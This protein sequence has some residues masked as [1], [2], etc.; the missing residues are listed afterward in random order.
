ME[1]T[2]EQVLQGIFEEYKESYKA[3]LNLTDYLT[4]TA[5]GMRQNLSMLREE[6]YKLKCKI[7]EKELKKCI[8]R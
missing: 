2:D 1:P 4:P 6:F 7:L 3:Y 8:Y 5:D